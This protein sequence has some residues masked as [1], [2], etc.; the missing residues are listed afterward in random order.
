MART[1]RI[2]ERLAALKA[3]A[4]RSAVAAR[5]L[6]LF[7]RRSGRSPWQRSVLLGVAAAEALALLIG[8]S[9][10]HWLDGVVA[11]ADHPDGFTGEALG[12][13]HIGKVPLLAILVIFLT[14][15][16]VDGSAFSS[17]P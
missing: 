6:A 4:T 2:D 7:R 8:A 12:W 9:A 1:H 11:D 13:L 14:T 3:S 16:A 10:S 15:F 17:R 5:E